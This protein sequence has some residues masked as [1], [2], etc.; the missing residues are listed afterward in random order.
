MNDGTCA[1]NIV[2]GCLVMEEKD[3]TYYFSKSFWLEDSED[4]IIRPKLTESIDVDIAILGAGFTGL[5]T[6]YYLIKQDPTLKIAILEKAVTG[7]GASGRNGG[8]CSPKFSVTPKVALERFGKNTA[9]DL[10][11]TMIDTVYEIERVIEEEKMNV[12]W[13]NSGSIK[14]AMGEHLA[15]NLE[16]E[17]EVYNSLGLADNFKLLNKSEIDKRV[18]INGVHSGILTQPSAV[19]HP[20][21]LVRQLAQIVE[22]YGVKIYEQTYVQQIEEGSTTTSPKLITAHG[23]VTAKQAVVIAGEAYLSRM[24]GFR[25]R[26]I[27]MYTSIV[28]TEPLSE[29]QWEEIGWDGRETV[30]S[31]NLSVDYLQRTIDGRI[32]FGLGNS[33]PYRFASQIKDQFDTF[34]PSIK[35]QTERALSWFPSLKRDQIT[36]AWGGPIG[37]TRDWTPN[38][39]YNNVSRVAHA[40]GYG[41]QGVSTANL[42][43]RILTQLIFEK[44]SEITNLPM[45]H[46][47]SRRWEPEPFR[48]IGA[49]YIKAKMNKLDRKSLESGIAPTGKS[50][51]ERLIRH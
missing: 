44:E 24:K 3:T 47:T 9:K 25:G 40:W 15:P 38:F 23:N 22:E 6:A 27:P 45:V 8:W 2:E 37:V 46:H 17:M 50:I 28:L 14:V 43:G 18:K 31:N 7:F 26:L 13:N 12:D 1:N 11:H 49:K 4:I 20:G 51:A 35:L 5:W 19:V 34:A 36:H 16:D 21:K 48:W 10:H 29:E 39:R 41:G 32:L 33:G 30:G 42:A